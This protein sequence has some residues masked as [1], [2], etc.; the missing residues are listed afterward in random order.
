LLNTDSFCSHGL[1]TSHT[2]GGYVLRL[3]AGAGDDTDERVL[4]LA[5]IQSIEETLYRRGHL[6]KIRGQPL[7]LVGPPETGTKKAPNT[8]PSNPKPTKAQASAATNGDTIAGPSRKAPGPKPK[9]SPLEDARAKA[10]QNAQACAICNITP[11]HVPEKCS[12][13]NM[14]PERYVY[15]VMSVTVR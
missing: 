2:T 7:Y 13:I 10:F 1:I 6:A 3:T 14:G 11:F 12:V 5:A 8:K 9:A 4:Q 15:F